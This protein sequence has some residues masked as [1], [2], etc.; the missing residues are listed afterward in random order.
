M[1]GL[2]HMQVCAVAD[3]PDEEILKVCNDEN[4]CGTIN[5][6]VL[7][8]R[9]TEADDLFGDRSPVVCEKEE[10]RIHFLVSC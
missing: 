4:L 8:C 1:V 3:A 9:S 7:V 6:W 10:G 2:C 5:G